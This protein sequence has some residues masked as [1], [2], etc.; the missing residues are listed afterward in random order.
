M[1]EYTK[2]VN[3]EVVPLTDAEISQRQAEE[4]EQ[5]TASWTKRLSDLTAEYKADTSTIYNSWLS[6]TV[7]GGATEA[8]KKAAVSAALAD[9]KNQY[10]SD[11]AALRAARP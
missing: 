9:R 1:A 10:L 3:G 5:A 7:I 11:L 4:T 8:A 6:A 2:I